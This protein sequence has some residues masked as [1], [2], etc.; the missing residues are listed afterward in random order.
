MCSDLCCG[1]LI[2]SKSVK[3]SP[4]W[5][6][7]GKFIQHMITAGPWEWKWRAGRLNPLHISSQHP[8][9]RVCHDFENNH[10][11]GK[12]KTGASPLQVA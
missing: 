1:L 12:Q 9:S 7:L 8:L 11:T 2:A 10:K 4:A 6:Q 3:W 5:K